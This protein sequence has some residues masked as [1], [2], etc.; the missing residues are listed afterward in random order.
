MSHSKADQKSPSG[1][2]GRRRTY[3]LA[4]VKP[5]PESQ[6]N[7][8]SQANTINEYMKWQ[9]A[10]P[11]GIKN[12]LTDPCRKTRTLQDANSAKCP[13]DQ[14]APNTLTTKNASNTQINQITQEPLTAK[15]SPESAVRLLS[16]VKRLQYSGGIQDN[17]WVRNY[18]R[19]LGLTVE[20]ELLKSSG[21]RDG[22]PDRLKESVRI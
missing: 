16:L 6:A 11:D 7:Q 15:L 19:D 21:E 1:L 12:L 2:R 13:V 10:N 14:N 18:A 3:R 8:A 20:S 5:T 9:R 22:R 17:N 4:L